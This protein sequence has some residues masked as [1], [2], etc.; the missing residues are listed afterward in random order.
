MT[1]VDEGYAELA[2]TSN[3]SFLHGGSH[4]EELAAQ[5]VSLGLGALGILGGS[6]HL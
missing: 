3:F 1:G 6:I 4:P 5:A 2:A